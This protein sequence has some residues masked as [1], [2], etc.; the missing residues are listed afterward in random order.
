MGIPILTRRKPRFS[1]WDRQTVV[2]ASLFAVAEGT[3]ERQNPVHQSHRAV[4]LQ[5]EA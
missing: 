1:C 3:T 2:D 5:V 4:F